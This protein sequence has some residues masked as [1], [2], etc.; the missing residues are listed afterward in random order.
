M[1]ELVREQKEQ[2]VLLEVKKHG[3]QLKHPSKFKE[4]L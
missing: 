2:L 4:I 3:L 1:Q